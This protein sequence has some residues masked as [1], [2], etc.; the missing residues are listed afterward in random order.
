VVLT[1]IERRAGKGQ[2][3]MTVFPVL[4]VSQPA[5]NQLST[6][7]YDGRSLTSCELRFMSGSL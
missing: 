6:L 4:L 2:G 3:A 1:E 5:S 7:V